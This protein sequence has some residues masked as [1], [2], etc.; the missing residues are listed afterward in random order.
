MLTREEINRQWVDDEEV[1]NIQYPKTSVVGSRYDIK[2]RYENKYG[3]VY[4][5]PLRRLDI[6]VKYSP[7]D[8]YYVVKPSEQ[9]RP[10]ILARR[11][12]MD[13]RLYWVI[14]SANGMK[15]PF[16][17]EAGL[18]IRIPAYSSVFSVG[19]VMMR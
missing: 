5:R 1:V 10:D 13:P 11:F 8:I 12:L 18:N 6:W 2:S 14:L 15:E 17:L 7:D 3:T 9:Y 4:I 16:E 19:G